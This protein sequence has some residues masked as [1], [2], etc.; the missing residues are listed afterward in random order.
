MTYQVLARKWR[1]RQFDDLVGQS[2]IVQVLRQA[3]TLNRLHHAYLF[4]G[5][6]GVGKTTLARIIAKC[7]NCEQ[8]PTA[9]PC[10]VCE[11]C[12][13]IEQGNHVDCLE[14]D[15]ASRTKV[16]ETRELLD[17]VLYAPTSARFKVYIIDEVHML[18]AHSFNALL[19]TLEEPPAH[20][21]FLFATTDPQKLPVTILSRCLQLPLKNLTPA[22]I[23][24]HLAH[25]LRE[26]KITFDETALLPIAKHAEGSVRDA[27]SLLEQVINFAAG[28]ITADAVKQCLGLTDD[29]SVGELLTALSAGDSE[30]LINHARAIL[31]YGVSGKQVLSAMLTL[32]HHVALYQQVPSAVDE[33]QVNLELVTNLATALSAEDTQLYYQIGLHGRRDLALAPTDAIGLEMTLL[34]MLAFKPQRVSTPPPSSA[35]PKQVSSSETKTTVTKPQP[36]AHAKDTLC[37]STMWY[38]CLD[39]LELHGLTRHLLNHCQWRGCE[40]YIITLSTSNVLAP[41]FTHD[42][43]ERIEHALLHYFKQPFKL[44]IEETTDSLDTPAEREVARLQKESDD[45]HTKIQSDP[46]LKELI[47]QFDAII[48][49]ETIETV[50]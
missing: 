1:P 26:E 20:V 16:E 6:R 8:G 35:T 39:A 22:Q 27:L 44:Q 24:G 40:R 18:S 12:V 23:E 11:H 47:E 5:T 14:I 9:N 19:K 34:R 17:N 32:L 41:F 46:R 15:A 21:K 28:N 29:A 31:E 33:S 48:L 50:H 43:R 10:G 49:S 38:D 42:Q 4:T 13:A 36:V 25:V 37:S 2:H 3:F 7:F 30:E 45:L